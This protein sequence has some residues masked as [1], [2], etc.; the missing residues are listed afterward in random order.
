MGRSVWRRK[1]G[2]S[3]GLFLFVPGDPAPDARLLVH[4]YGHSVQSLA[5]GPLY[6]PVIFLP[7]ACW[8][9]LPPLRRL[10]RE[11]GRSY[12]DFYTERWANRWGEKATGCP[13]MGRARID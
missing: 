10:R 11:T 2:A 9:A 8:L 13:A 1:A 4:E 6:L 5:L 3:L 12:Y 7:S